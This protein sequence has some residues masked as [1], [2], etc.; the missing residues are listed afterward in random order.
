[1]RKCARPPAQVGRAL[2][3]VLIFHVDKE[4]ARDDF[5]LRGAAPLGVVVASVI[6][7]FTPPASISSCKRH[8]VAHPA[9]RCSS[10]GAIAEPSF[11]T[12]AILAA[13]AIAKDLLIVVYGVPQVVRH[14]RPARRHQRHATNGN[15]DETT[16]AV[17]EIALC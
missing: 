13:S 12:R 17:D 4:L 11:F 5:V 3:Q 2:A 15:A 14:I 7:C 1:M 16:W 6:R 10:R 8:Q 9:A